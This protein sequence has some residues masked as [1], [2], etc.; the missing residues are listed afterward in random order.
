MGRR[1]IKADLDRRITTTPKSKL[2]DELSTEYSTRKFKCKCNTK[3]LEIDFAKAR[4][5]VYVN[6]LEEL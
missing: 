1:W 6:G 2:L 4:R 3:N 5:Y